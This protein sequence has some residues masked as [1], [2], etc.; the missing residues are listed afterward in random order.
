[1][2]VLLNTFTFFNQNNGKHQFSTNRGQ[3]YLEKKNIIQLTK[4]HFYHFR[5]NFGKMYH[6]N[7]QLNPSISN[8]KRFFRL[9][10][11]AVLFSLIMVFKSVMLDHMCLRTGTTTTPSI[12][13]P[14]VF[15]SPGLN[16]FFFIKLSFFDILLNYCVHSLYKHFGKKSYSLIYLHIYNYI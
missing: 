2:V 1:M 11:L 9:H 13:H 7:M 14:Q 16:S 8:L 3:C 10:V 12:P 4:N 5:S 15:R 6:L